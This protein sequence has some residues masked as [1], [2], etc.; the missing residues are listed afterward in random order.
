[1]AWRLIEVSEDVAQE[2]DLSDGELL[3]ISILLTHESGEPRDERNVYWRARQKI[4]P[5]VTAA[6]ERDIG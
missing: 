2:T 4:Q 6:L 5:Q 1:M 3:G